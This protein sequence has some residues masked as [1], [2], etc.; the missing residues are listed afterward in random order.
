[1]AQ[2]HEQKNDKDSERRL[3]VVVSNNKQNEQNKVIVIVPL[4]SKVHN[5]KPTFQ[6]PTL[7]QGKPGKAKCEQVRAVDV[8]SAGFSEVSRSFLKQRKRVK[9][10]PP[11]LGGNELLEVLQIL[12][13][14]VEHPLELKNLLP[15]KSKEVK[16]VIRLEVVLT[17]QI[18]LSIPKTKEI[19]LGHI[20][21]FTL[22]K[23]TS[24]FA[25]S[26]STAELEIITKSELNVSNLT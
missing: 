10:L 13:N 1:D 15:P 4:S 5:I 3:V 22:D 16:K 8:E 24:H 12:N 9:R 7:F 26:F 19:L 14:G 17:E 18:N 6:A 21:K 23:L 25:N 2:G 11:H 20:H